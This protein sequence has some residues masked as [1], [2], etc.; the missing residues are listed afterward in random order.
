M[1]GVARS[2]EISGFRARSRAKSRSHCVPGVDIGLWAAPLHCSRGRNTLPT[3]VG[4]VG[5]VLRRRRPV[6]GVAAMSCWGRG[7]ESASNR[8]RMPNPAAVGPHHIHCSWQS[9][10]GQSINS[11]LSSSINQ[12]AS[13]REC[14]YNIS[15]LWA[16]TRPQPHPVTDSGGLHAA[17]QRATSQAWPRCACSALFPAI[18]FACPDHSATWKC[19]CAQHPRPSRQAPPCSG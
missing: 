15:I 16:E 2:G 7:G 19:R 12:G 1:I 18:Y 4:D 10:R 5:A 8:V 6:L 3:P 11:T 9:Q 17:H 14:I 13:S